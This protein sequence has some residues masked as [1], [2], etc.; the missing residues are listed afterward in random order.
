MRKYVLDFQEVKKQEGHL[1]GGKGTN[2]AELAKVPGIPVPAGFCITTNAYKRMV[3][4]NPVTAELMEQLAEVEPTEQHKIRAISERLRNAIEET[5]IPEEIKQEIIT[6][7]EGL[8]TT[9]A[10]AVR[11]SATA[12]DLPT[13]SFAGQQDS[14]LNIHG[15]E[16]LLRHIRKCW[17]SLFTE[18]AVVY[19]IKNGF[20]HRKVHLSVVVQQ[21]VFPDAS[22]ILFTADPV[23]SNRKVVS[24]DASFG[25]GEAL[26]SGIVSADNYKVREGRIIGKSVS[27]KKVAVHPMRSGGTEQREIPAEQQEQQAI[28]DEVILALERMG[29]QIEAHFGQPQDIEWCVAD[30][31]IY[32]LQSRPITTL[33]PLPEGSDGEYRLYLSVGH[34]QMMTEPIYPL[35]MSF[36]GLLTDYKMARAGGHLFIDLSHDLASVAGRSLLVSSLGSNDPLMKDALVNFMKR[37]PALPKGTRMFKLGTAQFPWDFPLELLKLFRKNDRRLAGQRLVQDVRETSF[38][39]N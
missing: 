26:V 34:Q 4:N 30:G 12:E 16:Q 35:G 7:F 38:R 17:A 27:A 24:I 37:K 15:K 28:A 23:T 21:M 14:F 32:I 8:G 9:A 39:F 1:V 3:K 36:F 2:L 18:R 20:D 5:K 33:Y 6:A 13:A 29:R 10:Y 25:L 19:R 22:G 11:S 31:K